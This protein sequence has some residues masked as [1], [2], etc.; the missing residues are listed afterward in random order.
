MIDVPQLGDI[1]FKDLSLMNAF[2]EIMKA[3]MSLLL[4][5]KL[6]SLKGIIF[7]NSALIAEADI[8]TIVNN[9]VIVVQSS[10][11]IQIERLKKRAI[12]IKLSSKE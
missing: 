4:R 8:S 9:D 2:D 1:I 10:K 11:E 5:R 6:L 12:L 3:P 7:I